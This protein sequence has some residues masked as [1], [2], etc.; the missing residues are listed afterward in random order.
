MNVPCFTLT[1]HLCALTTP[2]C[3]L[4]TPP[5]ALPH[6]IYILTTPPY[7]LS[8]SLYT[9]L[10]I[11]RDFFPDQEHYLL[12]FTSLQVTLAYNAVIALH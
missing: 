8:T 5:C 6:T 2:L 11:V 1:T 9:L 4:S 10:C 3:T 7:T 12:H